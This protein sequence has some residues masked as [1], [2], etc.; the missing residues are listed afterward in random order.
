MKVFYNST[1]ALKKVVRKR[2]REKFT[3]PLKLCLYVLFHLGTKF[4]S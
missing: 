1:D 2:E 3:I 4:R